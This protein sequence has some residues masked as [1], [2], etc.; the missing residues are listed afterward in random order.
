M[1]EFCHVI[2]KFCQVLPSFT[3]FYRVLPSYFGALIRS[4]GSSRL[5]DWLTSRTASD[6]AD[7]DE[8]ELREILQV[9]TGVGVDVNGGGGVDAV[10]DAVDEGIVDEDEENLLTSP[11][12]HF[13]PIQLQEGDLEVKVPP[14]SVQS[15]SIDEQNR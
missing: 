14:L 6:G 8:T 11:K 12:T 2:F 13:C 4:G 5:L 3:E 7:G 15:S 9:D 1:A 10:A